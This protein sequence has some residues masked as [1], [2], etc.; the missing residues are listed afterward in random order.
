M[1]PI[2]LTSAGVIISFLLLLLLASCQPSQPAQPVVYPSVCGDGV[3]SANELGACD[4]DCDINIQAQPE[5]VIQTPENVL[6][7][8]RSRARNNTP[9]G[10]APGDDLSQPNPVATEDS[11]INVESFTTYLPEKGFR[12]ASRYNLLSIGENI[13]KIMGTLNQLQL[14]EIL[15]GGSLRSNTMAFGPRAA[16][17]QQFLKLRAGK[18]LFGLDAEE[19]FITTYILFNEE[20][21]IFDYVLEL[22]GGIFKFFEG[23]QIHFLGHDYVI[24]EVTNT[25]MQLVGVTTPDT[26]ILRNQR[27]VFV[28]DKT[29][30]EDVLNI[31][32]KQDYLRI[33][34]NAPDE[35]KILP[36]T[37]LR[38]Y[39]L[40][41]SILLTNRLDLEYEGLTDAP[42]YNIR[43]RKTNEKYKLSFTTNKNLTYTV[44]L[45]N[46]N[47]FKTGDDEVSFV[48]K[49]GKNNSDYVIKD[50]DWF[51]VT[52]NKEYNGLTNVI[53]LLSIDEKNHLITFQDPALEKFLIY[54]KGTPGINATG[55]LIID[56]VVHKVYV[57][58]NNDIAVDLD[59]NG[60]I[61]RDIAP[62]VTA[63]NGIIMIN[64]ATPEGISIS[65]ITPK[66]MRE[67]S[68]SDLKVNLTITKDGLIIDKSSLKLVEDPDTNVLIGMTDYGT[69]FFLEKNVNEN[70]QLGDDLIINY[71]IAQRFADVIVKAYE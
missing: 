30:S 14:R 43:L 15:R 34:I 61:S 31:T 29:I 26:I 46:L 50:N 49:E 12:V 28:N 67:N 63:G 64:N 51:V 68:K 54:F 56:R 66:E 57:G 7:E 62:I 52:N 65:I 70:M 11:R 6:A 22:N 17:Y 27:G 19:E 39:L 18:V 40:D 35:L 5:P 42:T 21:P 16:M 33:I 36:G 41:Q 58:K 13:S 8:L 2:V 60:R 3:C 23:E 53:K 10:S 25:T 4:I 59:G 47:P 38:N 20:E 45:I 48:F 32:F 55:E 9:E 24:E 71:P 44:P 37:S 1:K 69:L